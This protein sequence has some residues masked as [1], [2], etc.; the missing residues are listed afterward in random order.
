MRQGSLIHAV[1]RVRFAGICTVSSCFTTD[2]AFPSHTSAYSCFG[3][4]ALIT[5]HLFIL[6]SRCESVS[7]ASILPACAF[8]FPTAFAMYA[9][10]EQS[11]EISAPRYVY[12]SIIGDW[13]FPHFHLNVAGFSLSS[14]RSRTTAHLFTFAVTLHFLV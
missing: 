10:Q 13:Y 3:T 11:C 7:I 8:P 9:S 5:I 14:V 2:F 12:R 4:T 6:V 1:G